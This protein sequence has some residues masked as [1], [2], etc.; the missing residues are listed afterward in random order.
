MPH[1]VE[2][3][4][5]VFLMCCAEKNVSILTLKYL[6]YSLATRPSYT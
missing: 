5:D 2:I 4:L 6:T 1:I 3:L